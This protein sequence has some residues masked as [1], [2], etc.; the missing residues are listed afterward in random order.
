MGQLKIQQLDRSALLVQECQY[1]LYDPSCHA[2]LYALLALHGQHAQ[3]FLVSSRMRDLAGDCTAVL[4]Q[5]QS[6][7][8]LGQQA[9]AAEFL[10]RFIRDA[11]ESVLD[12]P[13]ALFLSAYYLGRLYSQ[14]LCYQLAIYDLLRDLSHNHV[15]LLKFYFVAK[16]I[17][18]GIVFQKNPK[19]S[20]AMMTYIRQ[21][22]CSYL[23]EFIV[24]MFVEQKVKRQIQKMA[25]IPSD[26]FQMG[27]L[28]TTFR[29]ERRL[30]RL[31]VYVVATE[32]I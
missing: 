25:G 24:Q 20:R 28:R 23:Y 9:S 31:L 4:K 6:L 29:K 22:Q 8:R 7:I 13:Y 27:R 10:G 2:L 16:M 5:S 1:F 32:K 12:H 30:R 11:S 15:N 26:T 21:F 3:A 19:K 18:R 17:K 14:P